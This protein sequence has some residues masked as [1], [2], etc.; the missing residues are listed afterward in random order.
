MNFVLTCYKALSRA[1]HLPKK[2]F[3]GLACHLSSMLHPFQPQEN[4]NEYSFTGVDVSCDLVYRQEQ[5]CCTRLCCAQEKEE[6]LAQLKAS[7]K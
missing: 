4:V 1:P 7:M 6:M 5:C 2:Q 3:V